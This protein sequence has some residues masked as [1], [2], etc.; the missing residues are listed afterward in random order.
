M[1]PEQRKTNKQL[2]ETG[3]ISHHQAC[4]G[5]RPLS[6]SHELC[7]TVFSPDQTTIKSPKGLLIQE[8]T[9]DGGKNTTSHCF[10]PIA[11]HSKCLITVK[12]QPK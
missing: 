7:R 10:S 2:T 9:V 6:G 8:N 4:L 11:G 5:K 12:S 3:T 1:Q